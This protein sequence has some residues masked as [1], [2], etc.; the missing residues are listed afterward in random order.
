MLKRNKAQSAGNSG[1]TLIEIM[2]ALAIAAIGLVAVAQSLT[3]SIEVAHQL[4]LRTIANW[5][6]SNKLAEIRMNRRF[7]VSGTNTSMHQMAGQQWKVLESYFSTRDP[8]IA[9][10]VIEVFDSEEE[11]SI[12]STTSYISKYQPAKI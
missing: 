8:N 6:S 9:R 2:V 11:L 1:F 12:F 3:R 7:D 4:E 10:V 5:V